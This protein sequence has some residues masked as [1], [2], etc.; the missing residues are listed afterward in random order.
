MIHYI[1]RDWR[2]LM[3]VTVML[4]VSLLPAQACLN[5]SSVTLS[6]KVVE[7]EYAYVPYAVDHMA[8]AQK[9]RARLIVLDSLWK[10]HGD[11]NAYA[12]YGVNLVYL[13]RYQEALE[14]FLAVEKMKPGL[15]ATAANMGTTYELLGDN[16]NALKWIKRAVEID[17]HSHEGSEW[18]HVRILEAKI[19]SNLQTAEHLIGISFG[20]DVTPVSKK[21]IAFLET[22]MQQLYYQLS[23]RMSFV[24]P[25]DPVVA[26]LLFELGNVQA[27][28][29]DLSTAVICYDLAK[30]YGYKSALLDA[31]S[32]AFQGRMKNANIGLPDEED[33]A[34]IAVIAIV[35]LCLAVGAF[36]LWQ[37]LKS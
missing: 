19:N 25:E 21:S 30:K 32:T 8:N 2:F 33:R 3:L 29:A 16:Q 28:V 20:A 7:T 35:A 34:N 1:N 24:K 14:V 5:E 4:Y 23:E 36:I 27:L 17:E 22:L 18:I 6:G 37:R 13:G 31:R 12:D 11:I 10:N 15:Y 26:L 9:Y